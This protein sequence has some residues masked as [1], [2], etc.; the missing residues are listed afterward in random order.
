MHLPAL[1]DRS[2]HAKQE[3]ATETSE[4]EV[5]HE[6]HRP[7][8]RPLEPRLLERLFNS[9]FTFEDDSTA[10]PIGAIDG[11]VNDVFD[12]SFF[13][14]AYEGIALDDI[15]FDTLWVTRTRN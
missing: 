7:Y 4:R 9:E 2:P 15:T 10:A 1:E 8:D 3:P 6:A 5:L 14:C 11:G 12:T 13:A